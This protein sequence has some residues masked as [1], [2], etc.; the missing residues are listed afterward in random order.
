MNGRDK[1][2]SKATRETKLKLVISWSNESI[3]KVSL[4]QSLQNQNN[5]IQINVKALKHTA[6][7]END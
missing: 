2:F 3:R 5:K 4:K 6:N 1:W 7:L